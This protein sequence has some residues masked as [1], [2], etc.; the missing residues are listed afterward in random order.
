MR[1][2]HVEITKEEVVGW[3]ARVSLHK[4]GEGSSPRQEIHSC[5]EE[6]VLA[7]LEAD[8]GCELREV[9]SFSSDKL[10]EFR[11]SSLGGRNTE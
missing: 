1:P 2:F 6:L 7:W 3:R 4:E 8:A 11:N 9:Y 10:E 5:V